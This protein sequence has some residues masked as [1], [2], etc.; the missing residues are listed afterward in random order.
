[1]NR[2]EGQVVGELDQ[3]TSWTLHFVVDGNE[4]P[5]QGGYDLEIEVPKMVYEMLEISRDR[6]WAIS[7]HRGSIHVLPAS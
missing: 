4:P 6:R 2:M 7:M 5:A 3:G 1:M